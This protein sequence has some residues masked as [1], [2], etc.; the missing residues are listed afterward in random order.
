[1]NSRWTYNHI[2][3]IWWLRSGV[4]IHI[5]YPPADVANLM[6]IPLEPQN[7]KRIILSVGQFRREKDHKLQIKSFARLLQN[8]PQYKRTPTD[9]DYVKLVMLGGCRDESDKKRVEELKELVNSLK[10][11]DQ[12]EFVVNATY[13]TLFKLLSESL[14]GLHTMWNEHFGICV[15]EFQVITSPSYFY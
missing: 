11:T 3:A 10:I 4:K 9:K 14:I 2:R 15:V 7:R 12:V 1:M 13:D 6:K 5:V 8:W